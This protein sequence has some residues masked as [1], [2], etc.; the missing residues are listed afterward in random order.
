ME[1]KIDDLDRVYTIDGKPV[2]FEVFDTTLK[3][4][5]ATIRVLKG[6]DIPIEDSKFDYLT[7]RFDNIY[8]VHY[9]F[10]FRS[11]VPQSPVFQTK[12]IPV[13][14][15]ETGDSIFE[16]DGVQVPRR[17]FKEELID[18]LK[19]EG[20]FDEELE[21]E[22]DLMLLPSKTVV[23]Y[24]LKGIKFKTYIKQEEEKESWKML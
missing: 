2:T 8:L 17:I 9:G 10:D 14:L 22:L 19:D 1:T 16:L 20:Y 3:G 13:H 24:T 23:T 18:A 11:E 15:K 21:R 12:V 6:I 4:V 7:E 5:V